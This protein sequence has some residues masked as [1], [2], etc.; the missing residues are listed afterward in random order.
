MAESTELE[1]ETDQSPEQAAET[2][3]DLADE[4]VDGEDITVEGNDA[5]MTVPGTTDEITTELEATHEI[6]GEYDQVAVEIELD[7]TI[8]PDEDGDDHDS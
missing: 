4:L 3:R 1:T 6:R 5:R 7:W 2:L 8:V